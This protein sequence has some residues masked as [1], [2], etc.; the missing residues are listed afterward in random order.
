VKKESST[1]KYSAASL[2]AVIIPM[3]LTSISSQEY[4]IDTPGFSDYIFTAGSQSSRALPGAVRFARERDSVL[5]SA[6][7]AVAFRMAANGTNFANKCQSTR[8]AAIYIKDKGEFSVAFDDETINDILLALP[9][10]GCDSHNS[11]GRWLVSKN[12]LFIRAALDRAEETERIVLVPPAGTVRLTTRNGASAYGTSRL[13]NAIIGDLAEPY[14][15]FL[16][17]EGNEWGY[18]RF[19]RR[20]AIKDIGVD[21]E[22]VEVRRVGVGGTDY[23]GI[24]YLFADVQCNYVGYARGVPRKSSTGNGGGA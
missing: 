10:E 1:F 24:N 16:N 8:T 21:N 15:D 11:T 17:H 2:A 19:L 6:R 12:N 18:E 9:Q 4:M 13:I 14:A 20:S 5:Q 7:E 23:Y 3:A 22:K